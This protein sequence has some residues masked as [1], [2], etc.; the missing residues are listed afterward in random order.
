MSGGGG[1]PTS[2]GFSVHGHLS[3]EGLGSERTVLPRLWADLRD[4]QG[5]SSVL[6]LKSDRDALGRVSALKDL[7][8]SGPC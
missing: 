4:Q 3:A 2:S 5:T 7:T 8:I 1:A 6:V